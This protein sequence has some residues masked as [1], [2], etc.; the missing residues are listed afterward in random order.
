MDWHALEGNWQQ[1]QDDMAAR[2]DRLEPADVER[3]GGS[4]ER[5]ITILEERY[6]WSRPQA[7]REL[8]A[9]VDSIET[10]STIKM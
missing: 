4:A 1:L 2:W 7:E 10:Y 6:G 9:Y 3:A 5:L 8:R